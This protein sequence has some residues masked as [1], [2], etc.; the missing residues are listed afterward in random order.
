MLAGFKSLCTRGS[1]FVWCRNSKPVPISAAIL[2][3]SCQ[4]SGGVLPCRKRR[5]SK[6]PFAIYSYTRHP[7][8]GH[9]PRSRTMCG[10]R[11]QLNTS[12]CNVHYMV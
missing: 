11:M 4:G 3:L 9:A 2:N 6:L 5:S 10:C 12:T 7:Y 8:S 1:G